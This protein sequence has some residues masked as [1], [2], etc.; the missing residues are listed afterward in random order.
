MD[1]EAALQLLG[2]VLNP[3]A[4]VPLRVSQ[5]FLAQHYFGKAQDRRERRP[6]F[7]G[8]MRDRG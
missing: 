4:E 6:Q 7:V 2:R 3:F 5:F 1:I 8:Q